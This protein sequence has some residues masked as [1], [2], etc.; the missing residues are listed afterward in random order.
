MYFGGDKVKDK[1]VW[2]QE[3]NKKWLK[4]IIVAQNLRV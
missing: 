3:L 2:F 1:T 4:L